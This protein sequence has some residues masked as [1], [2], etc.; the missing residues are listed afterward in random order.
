M[1]AQ[2]P[3]T[4]TSQIRKA[5]MLKSMRRHKATAVPRSSAVGLA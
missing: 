5:P 1:T 4:R 2:I 3:T